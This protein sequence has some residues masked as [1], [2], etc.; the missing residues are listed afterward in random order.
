MTHMI[1]HPGRQRGI[2]LVM[3]LMFL[4][5]ITLI[6]LG[7]MRDATLELK[8]A[9]NEQLRVEAVQAAQTALDQV[10]R[11]ENFPVKAL[12]YKIC[13]NKADDP[14]CDEQKTELSAETNKK[15]SIEMIADGNFVCRACQTSANKF[16]AA[17][18]AMQ[19]EYHDEVNGGRA[20]IGQG[21]LLMAPTGN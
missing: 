4:V 12:N 6:A 14:E 1:S 18:F 21:M 9:G 2:A 5:I 17:Q 3:A 19:G 7:S 13:F 8:M 10:T 15:V 16:S 20:Q 11:Y